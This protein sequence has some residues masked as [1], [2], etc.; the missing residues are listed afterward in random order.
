[1]QILVK[2]A[3]SLVIIFTATGVARRFPTAGGLIAVMPLTGALVL[4]WVHIENKGD[5][6]VMEALSKGAFWGMLP[7][8]LFFLVAFIC[9]KRHWSL[10]PTLIACFATWGAGALIHHILVK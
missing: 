6:N 10:A 1:M 3:L 5:P 2:A 8:V 7:S 9:F 4:L